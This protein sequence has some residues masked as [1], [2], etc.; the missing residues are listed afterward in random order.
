[1]LLFVLNKGKIFDNWIKYA[2][3]ERGAVHRRTCP[4][5]GGRSDEWVMSLRI[6]GSSRRRVCI[7][8]RCALVEDVPHEE[9]LRVS[10]DEETRC[11]TLLGD[12]PRDQW[13]AGVVLRSH[14]PS[15]N[16]KWLWPRSSDDSPAA[17]FEMGGDWP[18]GP[19]TVSFVLLRGTEVAIFSRMH[20]V[21]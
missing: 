14:L 7:C 19:L 17:V 13:D 4:V 6:P 18:I 21:G 20:R 11:L 1:M 3:F 8:P 9:K 2:R 5:C 15:D 16:R 12:L 10:F